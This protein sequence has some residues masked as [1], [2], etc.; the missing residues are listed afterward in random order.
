MKATGLLR[1][2]LRQ[3]LRSTW[4]L[5]SAAVFMLGGL[6]L[7]FFGTTSSLLGSR[8]FARSL[9]ALTHLG[10]FVVPLMALLPSTASIAGDREH[11]N[12][13][14]LLAQPLAR[15]TAYRGRWGGVAGAMALALVATFGSIGL[16]AALRGVPSGLVLGLLALTLLLAATFVSVGLWIST[17]SRVRARATALGLG[18]WLGLVAL[19]SLGVMT[20]FVRWGAPPAALELWLLANPVEAYRVAALQILGAGPDL[21]GPVGAA[22]ARAL[23]SAGVVAAAALSLAAWT[24]GAYAAGRRHFERADV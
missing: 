18:V 23:G 11:G 21:T 4:F 20:T 19:G 6:A 1:W 13:S 15:G 12:L 5:V 10:L 9:A 16:V 17:V 3:A 14:F 8:G 24:V 7:L 2:E 22:L